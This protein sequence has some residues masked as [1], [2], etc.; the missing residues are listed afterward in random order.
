MSSIYESYFQPAARTT[1]AGTAAAKYVLKNKSP[2]AGAEGHLVATAAEELFVFFVEREFA[3]T[4]LSKHLLETLE[5]NLCLRDT[6]S[7]IIIAA[8]PRFS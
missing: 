5:I 4:R 8:N 7:R 1:V 2:A 3:G 6:F